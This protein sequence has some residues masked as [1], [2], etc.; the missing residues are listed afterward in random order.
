MWAEFHTQPSVNLAIVVCMARY[1][2]DLN[3]TSAQLKALYCGEFN[4]IRAEDRQG[5]L[6]S[7]WMPA[8]ALRA[9][10]G[11]DSLSLRGPFGL[12][13]AIRTP[14]RNQGGIVRVF[15]SVK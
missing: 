3:V 1:V 9:S 14:E 11:S 6:P 12:V 10:R 7:T 8:T 13:K 15:G 2:F 4:T 5:R